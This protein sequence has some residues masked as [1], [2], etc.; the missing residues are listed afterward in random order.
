MNFLKTSLLILGFSD[1][2]CCPLFDVTKKSAS[3]ERFRATGP[4]GRK[5]LCSANLT[6]KFV[7]AASTYS[8]IDG[9][10]SNVQV[11]DMVHSAHSCVYI[12]AS[13]APVDAIQSSTSLHD[14]FLEPAD[15]QSSCPECRARPPRLGRDSNKFSFE[16]GGSSQVQ[17]S[18]VRS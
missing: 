2:A 16:F 10:V 11:K 6:T 15:K 4:A 7:V 14:Y 5:Q 17:R 9:K 3:V 18:R 12:F 1:S 8:R 13:G